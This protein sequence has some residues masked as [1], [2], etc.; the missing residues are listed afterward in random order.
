MVNTSTEGDI[1]SKNFLAK[2]VIYSFCRSKKRWTR[3]GSKAIAI[4]V[5]RELSDLTNRQLAVVSNKNEP[6]MLKRIVISNEVPVD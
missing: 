3:L 1:Y 4:D 6:L 2:T 5:F